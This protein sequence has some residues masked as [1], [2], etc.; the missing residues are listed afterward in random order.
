MDCDF[1][2]ADDEFKGLV[3]KMRRA[4]WPG[5]GEGRNWD[6]EA[7]RAALGVYSD[8]EDEDAVREATEALDDTHVH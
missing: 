7:F 8:E 1:D 3:R 5:D 6:R 4:G 2:D